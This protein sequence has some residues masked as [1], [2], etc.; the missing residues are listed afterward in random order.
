VHR[1]LDGLARSELLLL[2]RAQLVVHAR[3]RTLALRVRLR[4]LVTRDGGDRK[5]DADH[6]EC[7]DRD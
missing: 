5:A 4:K 1:L 2:L 6:G 7:T 3:A